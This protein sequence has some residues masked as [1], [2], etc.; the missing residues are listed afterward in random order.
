[1]LPFPAA[2]HA[3]Q[4]VE[5]LG[6]MYTEYGVSYPSGV[7]IA[8]SRE[9]WYMEQGGGR[10]WAAVRVPDDCCLVAANGY[11]IGEIDPRQS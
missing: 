4:C 11:R 3:R 1:M 5:Y 10:T 6:N 9:I 8:D 2:I 7:G